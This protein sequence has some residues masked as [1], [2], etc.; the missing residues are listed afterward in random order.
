MALHFS[1][2]EFGQRL[3][4]TCAA[5]RAE[6]LDAMLIFRQ[7]SMYWLTGYDTFGYVYFQCLVLTADERM[8]LMTRS[9]DLRQAQLTS[10]VGD[11]RIWEDREGANPADDLREI[12]AE[13]DLDGARVGVEL[14]A[15]GLTGRSLRMLDRAMEGFCAMTDAS[16]LISRLRL[17]KSPAEIEYVERAA[18]LADDA[19]DAALETARPGAFE[20]DILAAMQGAV[21]RGGGDYSGNEFVIGS[22]DHA[23]LCRYQVGR[24]RLDAE[25]QL[26][27]EWAG[28]YR[29]Y[30]AA[31][32]R[33]FTVGRTTGRHRDLHAASME[34]LQ[35]CEARLRP[36]S[37]MGDV[38]RAHSDVFDRR[39]LRAH[40]LNAC[41][42]ALGTTF[43]PNWMDWPMFYR[44]NPV[45]IRPGMVFFVHM[46]LADS[47]SGTAMTL[48]RT[49]L[50]TE[51]GSRPLSRHPLDLVQV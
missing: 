42:Y 37:T 9:A 49:S 29:R 18:E 8:V 44:D 5:M 35:A 30:H 32:M 23:L 4:A 38:F 31:L 21:F 2:E 17:V 1:R 45:E 43:A 14:E 7:E 13:L 10:I 16:F 20:G 39:G 26:T 33:T 22:G 27:L 11:I 15:Y 46:I 19:F 24:R 41:G 6:R 34:A 28:V 51:T 40:R 25:D 47:D 50:V 12:M 36:G 48:A 3:A